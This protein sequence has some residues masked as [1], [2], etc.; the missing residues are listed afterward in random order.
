MLL[1]QKIL[2]ISEQQDAFGFRAGVLGI[3]I[4][5]CG[6]PDPFSAVKCTNLDPNL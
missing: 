3:Q 1:P 4:G 6:T 2:D 5:A